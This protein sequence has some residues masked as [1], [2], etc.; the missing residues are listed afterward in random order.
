MIVTCGE[1]LV[2]LIPEPDGEELLYRAVLGGSL[3]TVA[4][5]I[6]RLGGR[7]GYLWELSRDTLGRRFASALEAAGVDAAAVRLGE[8]ATPVAVVDRS[9]PEPRY[10]IADPDRVMFEM[11]LA[12]VPP[13]TECLQIGSAVLAHEPVGTAIEALAATVPF[14]SIDFN[15]RPPSIT[16]RAA[17]RARLRRLAARAGVVKASV[18]DIALIGEGDP[19][20][21]M[22][23]AVEAGAALGVLTAAGEGAYAFTRAGEAHV[24]SLCT[25]VVDP[26]GAGDSFMAAMLYRLQRDEALSKARLCGYDAG[27]LTTL[28]RFAQTAAAF[29]CA[30]RGAVMPTQGELV[31]DLA[32]H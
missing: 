25:A 31:G 12:A 17:Y 10:N 4:L 26:V 21:Y 23:Q 30:R 27:Q 9:G 15:A 22:R 11:E 6:A 28:L 7:S 8:R 13:N 14:V 5:G 2:D 16:D 18:A 20:A 3:Y 24:A 32:C 29:T 1:A 19:H